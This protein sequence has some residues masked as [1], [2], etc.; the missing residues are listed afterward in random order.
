MEEGFGGCI[1]SEGTPM[2]QL[3]QNGLPVEYK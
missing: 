3:I 2:D 1:D